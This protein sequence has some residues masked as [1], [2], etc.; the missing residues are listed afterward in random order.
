M[1]LAAHYNKASIIISVSVLLFSGIVYY[2]TINHI[3]RKQ[4]DTDLT[5][6]IEEMV[7]YVNVNHRLPK[8][9]DFDEDETTFVKTNDA[10]FTTVFFDAPFFNDKQKEHEPGRA[11]STII[12]LNGQNYIATVI[13][14]RADTE[15]LIQIIFVITIILSAVL[16]IISIVTNRYVLNGLWRPFYHILNQVQK[17]NIADTSRMEV[18]EA[19]VDEFRDLSDAVSKMSARVTT[20]YQGLKMFTENA[21]HEMMTPLAVITSKLDMLIQDETLRSDQFS[22][23]NDIYS[24][25]SRLSRLNQSLLLLVKIDNNLLPDIEKVNIRSIILD[26]TQQFHELIQN[27]NIELDIS[28]DDLELN[29]SKYLIDVLINNLFSNAIRHNSN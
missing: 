26:K 22:Q 11:I 8:P 19:K 20:D 28:V 12:K 27:K 6:E 16:L 25:A 15:D 1:K 7:D 14:S 10:N 13:E 18:I 2:L 21:S 3:A 23:I 17:F 5:E 29:T 4:L 9:L 24:A